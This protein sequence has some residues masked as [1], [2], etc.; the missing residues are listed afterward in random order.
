MNTQTRPIDPVT[1]EVLRGRF[2][3]VADEIE[4][5]ILRSAYSTIVTE[6]LDATAAVFDER[7]RTIA[8]ACAI[9]VHLGT[10]TELGR[11]FA[12]A[13]PAGKARAGDIYMIN[14]PYQG[15]THLP[16]IAVAAPVFC[17]GELVGYVATMTHHQDVGGVAP[18][19]TSTNVYDHHSEGLRIPMVRL[20]RD[21]VLDE[22][23]VALLTA[24]SRSPHNM[25]GDLLAQVAGCLTGER[26]LAAVFGE[27]G[28]GSVR[29]AIDALMDYA[30][31]LTRLAIERI[32]DGDY[33]FT[34]WLDNDGSETGTEPVRIEVLIRVR[35]S[36]VEFDFTGSAPQVKSAINN[37]SSST[38][39]AVYYAIRTLTG[40][41]APNNDGCYRPIRLVLP[42]ASIVN[43]EYP[44]PINARGVAL[45]RI[46]DT[47]MGAMAKA[48][49]DRMPAA[50]CGH[51]TVIPVG[52]YDPAT[53]KR[54]IGALGGPLRGGMGARPGKDGIDVADH[55]LSNSYHVPIEVTEREFPVR[56]HT[57]GLWT[58]SGGP[59]RYRGGLGYRVEL[60]WLTGEASLA[61]RRERHV[62]KPWGIHGGGS[63]PTCRTEL[64][65]ADG[66]VQQLPAKTVLHIRA[67]E[68]LRYW[69]TGGGGAYPAWTRDPKLV[70]TDLVD[71]RISVD[72][73]RDDYGVIMRDGVVDAAATATARAA[74]AAAASRASAG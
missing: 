5:A 15:G 24:N 30:E 17:D 12:A 46:A 41:A 38:L 2:D 35:G 65:R 25:H 53:G 45:A 44:A 7:G 21:G 20:A 3:A 16:D 42:T 37:V 59:G 60:E 47:V 74:L 56:Y 22:D 68:T 32:P 18:G 40:D 19:S 55:D 71:G 14:D 70:V 11:R 52:A 64:Q 10:L 29:T 31:R 34:D 23:I 13:Y 73:A 27:Y 8:Q 1:M 72:S 6:A 58:D 49:P 48:V 43:A 66:S 36:D 67:G 28:S 4:H 61:L 26:R 69:S 50:G 39:A 54:R 63:A 33:G 9:P 51:A 57:L 62:F